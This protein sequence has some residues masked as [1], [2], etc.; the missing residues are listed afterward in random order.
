MMTETKWTLVPDN[1]LIEQ[2]KK[3]DSFSSPAKLEAFLINDGKG[4]PILLAVSFGAGSDLEG[5]SQIYWPWIFDQVKLTEPVIPVGVDLMHLAD[6]VT[7]ENLDKEGNRTVCYNPVNFDRIVKGDRQTL[8]R[9]D[10]Y[11]KTL[12]NLS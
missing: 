6:S 9:V 10:D 11:I 5:S 12:T 4:T 8:E 1:E 2:I 7:P 3:E